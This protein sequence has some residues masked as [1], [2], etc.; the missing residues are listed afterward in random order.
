VRAVGRPGERVAEACKLGFTRCILPKGNLKG[1][2]APK[3][4]VVVGVGT[5]AEA[6]EKFF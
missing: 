3:G 1:L 5:I 2:K 4:M 6:M